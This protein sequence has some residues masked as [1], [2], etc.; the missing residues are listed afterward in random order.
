M[1]AFVEVMRSVKQKDDSY[2][3]AAVIKSIKGN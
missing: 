1:T 2:K 3:I